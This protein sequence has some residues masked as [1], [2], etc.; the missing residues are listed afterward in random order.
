MFD[1]HEPPEALTPLFKHTIP[2]LECPSLVI[3]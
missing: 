3:L 1:M 2:D